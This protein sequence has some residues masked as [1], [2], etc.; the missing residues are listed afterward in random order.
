M[1]VLDIALPVQQ[2]HL[3]S[4]FPTPPSIPEIFVYDNNCQLRKHLIATGD[5][6]FACTGL[7]V[8]VFH[9]KAKHRITDTECQQYCNPAAFPDLVDGDQWRVNTSICEE[10]NAWFGGFA[11]MVREMEATRY[12][13]FLDEMIKRRN[14]FTVKQLERRGHHPWT[15]P[16]EVLFPSERM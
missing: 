12:S 13:F 15:I 6:Y 2:D 14:R 3:K 7:P 8:D 4:V 16:I 5:T 11:S 10:T 9:F 1:N